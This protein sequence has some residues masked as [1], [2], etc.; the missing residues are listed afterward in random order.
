VLVPNM[1][2]DATFYEDWVAANHEYVETLV[3]ARLYDAS[4]PM[5]MRYYV[6]PL[7]ECGRLLIK[8]VARRFSNVYVAPSPVCVCDDVRMTGIVW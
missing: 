1:P 2:N 3:Q 4:H 8:E 7:T 6:S 5:S